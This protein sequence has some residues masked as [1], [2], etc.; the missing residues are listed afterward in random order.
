MGFVSGSCFEPKPNSWDSREEESGS[1]G[2]V[3][4]QAQLC[5]FD[6]RLREW[7]LIIGSVEVGALECAA[8]IPTTAFSRQ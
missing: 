4:G 1:A 8:A 2:T 6:C 3:F 5:E 7:D